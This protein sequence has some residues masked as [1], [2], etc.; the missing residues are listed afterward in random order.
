MSMKALAA[1]AALVLLA[2]CG[3]AGQGGDAKT[4]GK[5]ETVSPNAT[6]ASPCGADRFTD[7]IGKTEQE[8]DMVRLPRGH[9]WVCK[10]CLMT[11]DH[12]PARIN[13]DLDDGGKITRIWCG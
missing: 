3:Q 6:A 1:L 2:A 12:V 7:W 10:D 9:R 13:F 11:Q 4:Y 5:E 8:V